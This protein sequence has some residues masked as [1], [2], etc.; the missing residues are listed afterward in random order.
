MSSSAL[1]CRHQAHRC[2]ICSFCL[3]HV[4][5]MSWHSK[6]TNLEHCLVTMT[7]TR[8]PQQSGDQGKSLVRVFFFGI[9]WSWDNC[10]SVATLFSLRT[11]PLLHPQHT[12][13]P[14]PTPIKG[15][16]GALAAWSRHPAVGSWK[17]GHLGLPPGEGVPLLS[18]PA[19]PWTSPR[20]SPLAKLY[21][22]KGGKRKSF[23]DRSH[24]H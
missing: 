13:T 18:S 2:R 6:E 8:S 17:K 11:S 20:L 10:L 1:E 16:K 24:F 3:E 14:T 19:R 15:A 5:H 21:E 12:P 9:P 22:G 23:Y 7:G 4:T